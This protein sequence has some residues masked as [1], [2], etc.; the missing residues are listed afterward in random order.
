M[1]LE[2]LA[3]YFW[4]LV[5]H[6][7]LIITFYSSTIKIKILEWV[8]MLFRKEHN[9]L[10]L[11]DFDDYMFEKCGALGEMLACPLCFGFWLGLIVSYVMQQYFGMPLYYIIFSALSWPSMSAKI[12]MWFKN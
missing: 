2:F 10:T 1:T 6:A 8:L 9:V 12:L 11:Q 4:G 7:N 3:L 5:I